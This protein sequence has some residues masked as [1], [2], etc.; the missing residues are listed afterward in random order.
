MPIQSTTNIGLDEEKRRALFT[1]ESQAE[2]Q[3][4]LSK[5]PFKPSEQHNS[6]PEITPTETPSRESSTQ[7]DITLPEGMIVPSPYRHME[8]SKA[9]ADIVSAYN[10]HKPSIVTSN[11]QLLGWLTAIISGFK[12]FFRRVEP[13]NYWLVERNNNPE[14]VG[15]SNQRQRINLN[16]KPWTKSSD[17]GMHHQNSALIG[18]YGHYV[19]NVPLG[20][21]ARVSF[22]NKNVIYDEGQHVIHDQNFKVDDDYLVSQNEAYIHHKD[23]HLFNVPPGQY[24]KVRI[25]FQYHLLPPGKH[26]IRNPNLVFS[27]QTD[28][29]SINDIHIDNG[30][31][32]IFNI[33]AGYFAKVKIGN[34]FKLIDSGIHFFDSANLSFTPDSDLVK[35][36]QLHINHG[37][38][39]VLNIPKGFMALVYENYEPK[40]LGSGQHV[41]DNGNF[42]FNEESNLIS[43]S[44]SYISHQNIHR[45]LVKAGHIALVSIDGQ[46]RILKGRE[47]PYFFHSNNFAICKEQG[48]YTFPQS[49]KHLSFNGI[50]YMLP[51]QG[52]VAVINDGGELV[53]LPESSEREEEQ[54]EHNAFILESSTARFQ[55]F[56]DTRVQTIEFPSKAKIAEREKGGADPKDSPYERIATADGIDVKVK[57]VVTYQIED[58]KKAL[59]QLQSRKEIENHIERLVDA[60]MR[61]A[62]GRTS[63]MN[64]TNSNRAKSS[65]DHKVPSTSVHDAEVFWQD[66]VR[67]ELQSDLKE[68]GIHLDRLNVEDVIIV[69]DSIRTE[70]E[71]QSIKSTSAQARM[72]IMQT[73][74][75]L[76]RSEAM[77]KREMQRLEQETQTQTART[78]A[79]LELEQFELQKKLALAQ[80]QKD[81]DV[82]TTIKEGELARKALTAKTDL[83]VAT[84]KAD[85][86]FYAK[87]KEA[88]GEQLQQE[89][90]TTKEQIMAK[91]LADNPALKE[92]E[93]ARL[94][95][96]ALGKTDFLAVAQL[97]GQQSVPSAMREM[98]RGMRET[99]HDL[100][101]QALGT[102]LGQMM[103]QNGLFAQPV[104]RTRP[105]TETQ[106]LETQT[107]HS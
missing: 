75:Q 50:H 8:P 28:F 65:A 26:Q 63:Y 74:N 70:L 3:D 1:I 10:Q 48:L 55:E 43:Q 2:L 40:L 44:E 57:F 21:Y 62:F 9:S 56:L 32:H 60:D 105:E 91:L 53:I 68:F 85:A 88:E 86:M 35:Q 98:F 4:I 11:W 18:Q 14:L 19:L 23:I 73:E 96:D 77:Q 89:A 13:G 87:K 67:K 7:Q 17:L 6:I 34:E 61:R 81:Q 22:N 39:H 100:G 101:T 16:F 45:V 66:V 84:T 79:E 95:S 33:P 82:E 103:A 78:R 15:P 104:D 92:T 52:E 90:S 58:P 71:E 47:E 20:S 54:P 31:Q 83:T 49:T 102:G 76:A 94:F 29:A 24:A 106:Q 42:R 30:N 38:I 97:Y 27:P 69:N 72:A 25:G 5:A 36:T 51:D 64:L 41:I 99:G 107:L 80:A 46:T 93:I 37:N 59:K 12:K